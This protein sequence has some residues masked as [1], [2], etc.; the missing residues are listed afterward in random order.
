MPHYYCIC[1]LKVQDRRVGS[2]RSGSWP[3][4]LMITHQKGEMTPIAHTEVIFDIGLTDNYVMDISFRLWEENKKRCWQDYKGVFCWISHVL[5]I[6]YIVSVHVFTK[7]LV[8]VLS[9]LLNIMITAKTLQNKVAYPRRE[10][11]YS[12]EIPSFELV[13]RLPLKVLYSLAYNT[14]CMQIWCSSRAPR[15]YEW[16]FLI[17]QEDDRDGCL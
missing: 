4:P 9:Q 8:A 13:I 16:T 6:K 14:R 15:S 11:Q 3:L 17:K 12:V 1:K 5:W 10:S 2:G 7:I